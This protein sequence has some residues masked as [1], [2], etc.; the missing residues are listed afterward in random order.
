MTTSAQNAVQGSGNVQFQITVPTIGGFPD[1]V[2]TATTDGTFL[3]FNRDMAAPAK[4][5]EDFSS[6]TQFGQTTT[7]KMVF[8]M[9]VSNP[10][11][12]TEITPQIVKA[13]TNTVV[14]SISCPDNEWTS[15]LRF[16]MTTPTQLEMGADSQIQVRA[17]PKG[18]NGNRVADWVYSNVISLTPGTTVVNSVSFYSTNATPTTY[19]NGDTAR[20]DILGTGL[21]VQTD[22]TKVLLGEYVGEG[23]P[24]IWY[25]ANEMVVIPGGLRCN[26]MAG[27]LRS[28]PLSFQVKISDGAG[29]EITLTATTDGSHITAVHDDRVAQKVSENLATLDTF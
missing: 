27:N 11:Y 24:P 6:V 8:D 28:G 5:S 12:D 14:G 9:T 2:V 18:Q 20:L 26:W 13:G 3:H 10:L 19:T 7:G 1:I 21:I 29:G 15:E 23:F 17:K 22:M 16:S 25:Q 4:Q